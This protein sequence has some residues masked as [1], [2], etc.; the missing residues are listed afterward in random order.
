MDLLAQCR[1]LAELHIRT[2]PFW[3]LMRL[4]HPAADPRT[5]RHDPKNRRHQGWGTEIRHG[6]DVHELQQRRRL[7]KQRQRKYYLR[8]SSR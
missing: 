7:A 3:G 5:E 4:E 8:S 6:F 1:G 2:T